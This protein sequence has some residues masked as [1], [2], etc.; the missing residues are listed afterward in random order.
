[1]MIKQ[2]QCQCTTYPLQE[3]LIVACHVPE[4]SLRSVQDVPKSIVSWH[5]CKEAD[6]CVTQ[7]IFI[8]K[9]G[10]APACINLNIV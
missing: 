2:C 10:T 3:Q 6:L 9:D 8:L 1:M 4:P 5:N 7:S